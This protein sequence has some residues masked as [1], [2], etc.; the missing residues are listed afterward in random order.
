MMP[1]VGVSTGPGARVRRLEDPSLLRG[2]RRYTDDLPEPGAKYVAFVRSLFAHA[3]IAS[4]E[5]AAAAAAPGVAGV[6]TAETLPLG[7]MPAGAAADG[8]RRPVI[9]SGVVRFAGEIVAA[10]VADTRAHAVDAAEWVEVDYEALPAAGRPGTGARRRCAAPATTTSRTTSRALETARG[11]GDA[12]RP[13]P[14][15][16]SR[17]DPSPRGHAM[18][19]EPRGIARRARPTRAA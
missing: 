3:R 13:A 12:A 16:R 18:P 4:I 15:S 6:Y 8:M 11:D 2:E 7:P 17:R 14:E 9:A 5:T 19:M 10:V 1:P